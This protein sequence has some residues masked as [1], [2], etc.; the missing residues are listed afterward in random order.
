MSGKTPWFCHFMCEETF[1]KLFDFFCS[2]FEV[3]QFQNV[4]YYVKVLG[5]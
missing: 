4:Y 2:A 5:F 3:L 1:S